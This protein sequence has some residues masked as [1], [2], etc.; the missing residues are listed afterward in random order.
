MG[1]RGGPGV[2]G[3]VKNSNYI[4]RYILLSLSCLRIRTCP[5]QM[6]VRWEMSMVPFHCYQRV[7]PEDGMVS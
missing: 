7:V 3:R 1:S 6:V 5:K 4:S 2:K